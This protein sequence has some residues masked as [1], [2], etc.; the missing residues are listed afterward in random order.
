MLPE[1]DK[2]RGWGWGEHALHHLGCRNLAA[3]AF[4]SDNRH[5]VIVTQLSKETIM[6]CPRRLAVC[7]SL[8]PMCTS[9]PQTNS[10]LYEPDTWWEYS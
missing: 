1:R 6:H 3:A 2:D 8:H 9:K 5:E 7:L 4:L 10:W